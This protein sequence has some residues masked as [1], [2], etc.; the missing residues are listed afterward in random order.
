MPSDTPLIPGPGGDQGT[1]NPLSTPVRGGRSFA[2]RYQSRYRNDGMTEAQGLAELRRRRGDAPPPAGT[3]PAQP[4]QLRARPAAPAPPAQEAPYSPLSTVLDDLPGEITATPGAVAPPAIGPFPGASTSDPV[5]DLTFQGQPAHVSLSELI[6]GYMRQSDYTTKTQQAAEQLRQ[7]QAAAQQFNAARATLE[8]RLPGILAGFGGEFDKPV[9]WN[10][11]AAE[12]PIGYTQKDARFKTYQLA[13]AEAANLKELRERED[14]ARKLETQRAG[15]EF[16][17][18]VLPGWRD[19]ATRQQ[20]QALQSAHLRAVGFTPAEVAA[21]ELLDPRY[22]IILEESR[23]FRAVVA[24]HPEL[25]RTATVRPTPPAR[26]GDMPQ[27]MGGNGRFERQPAAVAGVGDAERRWQELPTRSGAG[28]REAAVSLIA[29]RRAAA[30]GQGANP[31]APL[32][33]RRR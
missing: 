11:L 32:R 27:A 33:G 22:I 23:R 18:S 9:D 6:R 12:D 1:G 10:K 21:N 29:A 30:N 15:H 25:L 17:M 8:A 14:H 28:A 5:F 19:P 26:R 2:P 7:A 31:L 24:A 4:G 13:L 3:E 16:L 20:L